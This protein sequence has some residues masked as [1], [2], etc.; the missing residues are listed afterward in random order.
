[1]WCE[2]FSACTLE[3]VLGW[4]AENRAWNKELRTKT[5]SLV[6]SRLAN[7]ISQADYLENRKVAHAEAAEC[8]RRA[9]ILDTQILRR[10]VRSLRDA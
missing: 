8:K 10:T 3:D 5:S 9:S 2:D 7:Q 1:M 4:R 6:N